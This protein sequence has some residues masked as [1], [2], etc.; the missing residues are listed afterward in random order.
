MI[1]A[2]AVRD[3][4]I[5]IDI[6]ALHHGWIGGMIFSDIDDGGIHGAGGPQRRSNAG[7]PAVADIGDTSPHVKTVI[8]R[9]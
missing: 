5:C 8:S 4:L 3:L 9:R 2:D 7:A 1:D 6:K